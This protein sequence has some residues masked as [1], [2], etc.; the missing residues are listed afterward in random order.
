MVETVLGKLDNAQIEDVLGKA[1]IGRV[2]CVSDGRP[3]V[4]PIAYVYE[5]G[6]V[7]GHSIAGKK[8]AAMRENPGVCFEVECVDDLQN[9]RSVIASGTFEELDEAEQEA[10]MQLLVERLMPLMAHPGGPEGDEHGGAH[11]P[12]HGAVVFRIRLDEKSGRFEAR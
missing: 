3:Y 7:Y 6:C 10:G 11:P 12:S 9:W 1:V 8:L 2:G 4:V 5:N